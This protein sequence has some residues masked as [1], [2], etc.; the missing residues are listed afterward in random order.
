MRLRVLQDVGRWRKGAVIDIGRSPARL[1]C[2]K[3]GLRF[4]DAFIPEE[5][6]QHHTERQAP[7]PLDVEAVADAVVELPQVEQIGSPDPAELAKAVELLGTARS[8]F[9]AL[10][11]EVQ[12]NR[13][14]LAVV[15]TA[16]DAEEHTRNLALLRKRAERLARRIEEQAAAQARVDAA[17]LLEGLPGPMEAGAARRLRVLA[18]DL[19]RHGLRNELER[20]DWRRRG[21]I[22]LQHGPEVAAEHLEFMSTVSATHGVPVERVAHHVR[23]HPA[24]QALLDWAAKSGPTP[25]APEAEAC[26]VTAAEVVA[27]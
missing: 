22:A 21:D 25:R 17:R 18:L 26:Q 2:Q 5:L 6:G 3:L 16:S 11:A 23:S 14:R 15:V 20:G 10:R 9:E 7:P 12:A 27:P 19:L 13:E 4:E 1:V 24:L 8:D